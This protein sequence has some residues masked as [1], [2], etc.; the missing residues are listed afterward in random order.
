MRVLVVGATGLIGSAAAARLVSLGHTVIAVVR[1]NDR[2]ARRLPTAETIVVDLQ[3]ATEPEAWRPHLAGVDAV[4]NCAGLLQASHGALRK[5][6]GEAVGALFAACEATGV[7]RVVHVSAIGVEREAASD[8][9]ETKLVGDRALMAR[10]LDWVILRPSVVVGRAAYGGSA[11]FRALARLPAVPLIKAAGPVDAVQLDDVSETIASM[12]SANAPARI[13]LELV[14][15]ERLSFEDLIFTYRR[16]L[17]ID[18]RWAVR[19]PDWLVA[20]AC[21]VADFAGW[22]GWRPPMRSNARRELAHGSVGDAA[23]WIKTTGIRPKSLAE[24]L[25]G[26]PASVQE[27]WFANLYLVKPVAFAILA[28]YWIVTGIVALGPG[29]DG[30]RHLIEAAG[31]GGLTAPAI[32]VGS[33][34]D[35][36]IGLAIVVRRSARAGLYAALAV[37][38][39]YILAATVLVPR[40]WID[41]LGPLLKIVPIIALNLV[42]LAILGDR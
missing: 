21:R 9:S 38:A 3:Q 19:V 7:R 40:L 1:V 24:A 27:H 12:L 15:P 14:G 4:V 41:P 25:A 29:W 18:N 16:W 23:A 5:V 10:D 36:I 37:S 26:E 35:I 13:V 39:F 17:G 8:F 22:L 30:G 34:V 28:G 32:V 42:C 33:V 31:F 20:A 2:A 6:H 11:L